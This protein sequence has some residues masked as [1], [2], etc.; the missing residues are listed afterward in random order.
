[1]YDGKDFQSFM[2]VGLKENR[3]LIWEEGCVICMSDLMQYL[4]HESGQVGIW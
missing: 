2:A 4:R 1:M 3:E